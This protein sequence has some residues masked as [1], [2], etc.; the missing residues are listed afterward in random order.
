[1]KPVALFPTEEQK[2]AQEKDDWYEGK[3]E[4][5]LI[6]FVSG[7]ANPVL[8]LVCLCK[9]GYDSPQIPLLA[10]EHTGLMSLAVQRIL[11]NIHSASSVSVGSFGLCPQI[12]Q[13]M[14]RK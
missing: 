10:S 14:D 9:P 5:V 11:T 12:Q 6:S 13:P 1:M 4:Q 3:M 8:P 7:S 2:A